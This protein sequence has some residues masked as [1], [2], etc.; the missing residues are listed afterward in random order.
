MKENKS[1]EKSEVCNEKRLRK[2]TVIQDVKQK[3]FEET[4]QQNSKG[5]FTC[6]SFGPLLICVN[7]ANKREPT[8]E[9]TIE[10]LWHC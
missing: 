2:F 1:K 5:D 8:P 3:K 6:E 4:T 7:L 10:L 9:I